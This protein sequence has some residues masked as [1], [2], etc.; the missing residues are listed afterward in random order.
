M[1]GSISAVGAVGSLLG[2]LLYQNAFRNQPFRRVLL[3]AQLLF[4]ASG[5]LDLILVLRINLILGVPDYAVVVFDA[6]VT[7][8]IGRLKWMPLLVLS[9]KLC[10]AGIE[11]TFFALLMSID[12]VGHFSAAW[13]GGLLLHALN[14]T[15]TTFDNLWLA[16]LIRSLFRLLPI[17]I[18]FLIPSTDPNM[19]ILP[20]DMLRS[21]K[22]EDSSHPIN[23]EMESLISRTDH[24]SSHS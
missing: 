20:T 12:H 15:R 8:M 3:L 2:V 7:H 19:A 14:V 18:L 11:G 23:T 1:V 24:N 6:A 16:I 10:P 9:S 13:A 5:M 21:K 17:G 4:G 22:S